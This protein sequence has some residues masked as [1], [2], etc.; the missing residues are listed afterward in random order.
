MTCDVGSIHNLGCYRNVGE[1]SKTGSYAGKSYAFQHLKPVL[2]LYPELIYQ[3][4]YDIGCLLSDI[5]KDPVVM[6]LPEVVNPYRSGLS[7]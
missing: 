3:L 4:I 6:G 1:P 2:F 7:Q 5:V